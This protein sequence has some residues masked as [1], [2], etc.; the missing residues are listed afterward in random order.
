VERAR[1]DRLLSCRLHLGFTGTQGLVAEG[2]DQPTLQSGC[3]GVRRRRSGRLTGQP[4][5]HE[6]NSRPSLSTASSGASHPGVLLVDQRGEPP[7]DQSVVGAATLR[8]DRIAIPARSRAPRLPQRGIPAVSARKPIGN[9]TPWR[10]LSPA[11]SNERTRLCSRAVP[12]TCLRIEPGD[13][14][15]VVAVQAFRRVWASTLSIVSMIEIV[16]SSGISGLSRAPAA[17]RRAT[18]SA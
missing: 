1:P 9:R 3:P 14:L 10:R 7:I 11:P 12:T 18:S 2:I 5:L 8:L 13:Q 16:S 6:R 4:L 15:T 17:R